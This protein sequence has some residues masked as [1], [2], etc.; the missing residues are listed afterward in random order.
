MLGCG[1]RFGPEAPR[2]VNSYF[3]GTPPESPRMITLIF[4]DPAGREH[5][6]EATPGESLMQAAVSA[7]VP[8]I[9]ASCG[10]NCVCA[11][12]HCYI[13][14]AASA[15]LAAPDET[16]QAM[17][18]C[19]AAPQPNSRLTCQVPVSETMHGMRVRVAESQH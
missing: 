15:Q 5:R 11:T 13:E 7:L 1:T 17:L 9:E 3:T 12:C 6:V 19:V 2:E 4:I 18:E 16:E 8:G 14:S 10:G